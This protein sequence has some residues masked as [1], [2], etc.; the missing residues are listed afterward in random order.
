MA[1]KLAEG[2]KAKSTTGAERQHYGYA[3]T[4]KLPKHP[5]GESTIHP[6]PYARGGKVMKKARGRG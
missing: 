1:K 2:P 3:L 5:T 6:K 4:G